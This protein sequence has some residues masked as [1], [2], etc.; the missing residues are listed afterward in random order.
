MVRG[1]RDAPSAAFQSSEAT[2][3]PELSPVVVRVTLFDVDPTVGA[4]TA[5]NPPEFRHTQT[6]TP[7]HAD[8]YP[9]GRTAEML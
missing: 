9:T 2:H 6:A 1:V 8:E 4:P 5:P 7:H 3:S